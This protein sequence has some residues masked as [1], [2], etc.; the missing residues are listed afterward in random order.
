MLAL[1][2]HWGVMERLGPP[3]SRGLRVG[4][5][6]PLKES[7]DAAIRRKRVLGRARHLATPNPHG[8]SAIHTMAPHTIS[9]GLNA[10]GPS[11]FYLVAVSSPSDVLYRISH[12]VLCPSLVPSMD[13]GNQ[14]S[15]CHFNILFSKFEFGGGSLSIVLEPLMIVFGG[16]LQQAYPS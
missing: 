11:K 10:G 13:T 15:F 4:K 6:W 8:P 2:Q 5:G 3:E 7:G 12:P 9:H 14:I 1:P 16:S